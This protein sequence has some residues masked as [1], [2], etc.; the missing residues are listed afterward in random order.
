MSNAR[1]LKQ[2]TPDVT[3]A[4]TGAISIDKFKDIVSEFIF[5]RSDKKHLMV[6]NGI[7]SKELYKFHRAALDV[8]NNIN[9]VSHL[10]GSPTI[11]HIDNG[12]YEYIRN[13]SRYSVKTSPNSDV[14]IGRT[15]YTPRRYAGSLL[16]YNDRGGD[17]IKVLMG[18]TYEL[19]HVYRH[20]GQTSKGIF[21][22]DIEDIANLL[23][24][25]DCNL[26]LIDALEHTKNHCFNRTVIGLDDPSHV[27]TAQMLYE[28]KDSM[29]RIRRSL[30]NS[31][32]FI[33]EVDSLKS[34]TVRRVTDIK[35]GSIKIPDDEFHMPLHIQTIFALSPLVDIAFEVVSGEY[36]YGGRDSIDKNVFAITQGVRSTGYY[37]ANYG[38]S[39]VS[40]SSL[41]LGSDGLDIVRKKLM[42]VINLSDEIILLRDDVDSL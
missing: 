37:L 38:L 5:D 3:F 10:T 30:I 22:G 23:I 4:D 34:H 29:T 32:N 15:M 35:A 25:E 17:S 19:E 21:F 39:I 16:G 33:H 42:D 40:M 7:Q 11:N 2:A 41:Y 26:V 8:I 1:Y 24:R 18:S 12:K 9:S 28:S 36:D 14:M 6:V 31:I 20:M 13:F 27:S